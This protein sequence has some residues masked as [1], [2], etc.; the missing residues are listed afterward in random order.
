MEVPGDVWDCSAPISSLSW[1]ASRRNYQ[2]LVAGE[3][4]ALEDPS[5]VQN[6]VKTIL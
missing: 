1:G 4:D 6:T 3:T 5:E 2:K